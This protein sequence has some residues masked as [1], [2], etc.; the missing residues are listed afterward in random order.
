MGTFSRYA[1]LGGGWGSALISRGG[2]L[3]KVDNGTLGGRGASA[4][5]AVGVSVVD[6]VQALKD[7]LDSMIRTVATVR[8][9][10]LREITLRRRG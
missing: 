2:V 8:A 5:E 6:G 7:E 4:I 3:M 10:R 1:A 9:Q